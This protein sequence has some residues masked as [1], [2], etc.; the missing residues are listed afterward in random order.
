M[1]RQA[2]LVPAR[3]NPAPVRAE[4][5]HVTP[6]RAEIVPA[7]PSPARPARALPDS[8]DSEAPPS[9]WKPQAHPEWRHAV[10]AGFSSDYHSRLAAQR[11]GAAFTI[12]AP[13]AM[14]AVLLWSQYHVLKALAMRLDAGIAT[15]RERA[16]FEA[17]LREYDANFDRIARTVKALTA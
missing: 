14:D 17:G 8:P 6:I 11:A 13:Q 16:A 10:W 12:R 15:E 1:R 2:A 7:R 5:L 3:P 4:V 9:W